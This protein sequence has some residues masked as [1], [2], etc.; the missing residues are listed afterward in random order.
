MAYLYGD[1]TLHKHHS[2]SVNTVVPLAAAELGA[3]DANVRL[4]ALLD[5]GKL[6]RLVEELLQVGLREPIFL[7]ALLV[8][9]TDIKN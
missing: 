6:C 7:V 3:S 4:I 8:E 2:V 1:Y 5:I 9:Q